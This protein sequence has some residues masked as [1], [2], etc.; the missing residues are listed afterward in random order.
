MVK[1]ELE[2]AE[3]RQEETGVRPALVAQKVAEYQMGM[4]DSS[5]SEKERR[6]LA[7][8]QKQD[9]LLYYSFYLLLNFAEDL[10]IE[11]RIRKRGIVAMLS[12]AL[13]RSN[14]DLLLVA[15]Q[16]LK[17]LSIFAENKEEMADCGV[18]ERILRRE[19]CSPPQ[20]QEASAQRHGPRCRFVPVR[21]DELLGLVLRTLQNL[22]FDRRLRDQMVEGGLIAKAVEILPEAQFQPVVLGLLYHISM[23]DRYKSLF[24]Y[25]GVIPMIRQQLLDVES[26]R[27]VPEL[28]ALTVNLTQNARNAELMCQ[29]GY[30]ELLVGK[31]LKTHDDLMFK[32]LRNISQVDSMGLKRM[33]KPYTER[34]VMMLQE[35]DVHAN[36]LV[37]ALGILGNLNLPE[38]GFEALVDKYDLITFLAEALQPE[39]VEDDI[40]LEIVVFLSVLC[41]ARTAG[42]IV[43]TPLIPLLM[44]L[45]TAKKQ[46]DEFVLQITYLFLKL[47]SFPETAAV[48]IQHTQAST[49]CWL[50]WPQGHAPISLWATRRRR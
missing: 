13:D 3:T 10:A 22:S 20:Q 27:Q 24:T 23:E 38:F 26:L 7:L 31:A 37:E 21:N 50:P 48:L 43:K 36:V 32:V 5:L 45:I 42:K 40:L 41:N 19:A 4:E 29:D 9:R 1:L 17:K 47:L 14:V 46:D 39:V 30:F 8:A 16:F 44:D 18:V 33:F 12:K 2:R 15:V 34:L 25:T 35:G 6:V 49:R 28:I 11:R